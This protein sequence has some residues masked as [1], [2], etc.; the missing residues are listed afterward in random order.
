MFIP[1]EENDGIYR[2]LRDGEGQYPLWPAA[3]DVP[4]GCRSHRTL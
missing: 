2:V 4:P 3:V 1:R